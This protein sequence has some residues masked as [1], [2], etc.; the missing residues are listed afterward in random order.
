[1]ILVVPPTPAAQLCTARKH[2]ADSEGA[3][4]SHI[5]VSIVIAKIARHSRDI[6]SV[7]RRSD[8]SQGKTDGKNR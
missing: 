2:T 4:K 1:M 5:I 7:E 6:I 3:V 8:I